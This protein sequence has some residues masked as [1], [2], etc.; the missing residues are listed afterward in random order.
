MRTSEEIYHRVRW[1]PRFDPARFVLGVAVRGAEPQR[2][3]LPAFV[4]GGDIPWHRVV[5]VEA[6][7]ERVWDRATGL[8]RI[9]ATSAGRTL[10]Q[11]TLRPPLFT[12]VTP[13]AWDALAGWQPTA[14]TQPRAAASAGQAT[15]DQLRVLTW[16]TLWDRYDSDRIDTA[17]RRP[18]LVAALARADA[19]VIALQEVEAELLGLLLRADW[20]RS[21]YTVS[22]DPAGGDVA[23]TGLVLLSRLPV[24]EAGRHG[25]GPHK[26]VTAMTV[27]AA[28]DA[29]ITVAVTHLTSDHTRDGAARREAELARLVDLLAGVPG[30]VVLLGDFNDGGSTPGD[31]LG[32]RDAW[33]EVHGPDDR[34]ATFDPPANPLAAIS[35]LTG[36]AS[37]LDR[38]LLRGRTLRAT[39]AT[40]SGT[41]PATPDGL[42]LSDHYGVVVDLAVGATRDRAAE[43]VD[44]RPTPCAS[45]RA[46]AEPAHPTEAGQR[47]QDDLVG[48]IV[49][50]LRAGLP[51]S[52]VHVVGSRRLGC[53][54]AE[55]DLDLVAVVPGAVDIADV[56]H[57]VGTALPQARDVRAVTG[58]RVR[59]LR[60]RCAEFGVDL[61]VVGSAG[62]EPASAVARRMDLG[63]DAAIALSAVS[64]ADALLAAVGPNRAA[65]QRLAR[66]VKQWARA[67]GLDSAPFGGL[68]G[69]AWT[70]L[71]AHTVREAGALPPDQLLRDFFGGWAAWDWRHPVGLWDSAGPAA[72]PAP[73]TGGTAPAV[74]ITTP[75]A[76]VRLCSDQVGTG[77]RDLLTQELYQAWEVVVAA[78]ER[79]QDPRPEL[80]AAPPLHRRHRAW[81]V[82]TVR[83]ERAERLADAV[84]RVRGRMRALL[85]A[86]DHAGATDAHAW[87]RPVASEPGLVR[88]AIGLGRTPPDA[89]TLAG[90]AQD[91]TAGLRGVSVAWLPG[92]EPP[93]PR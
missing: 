34:T 48:D 30:P 18:L 47:Q 4:P 76:P 23:D 53:A 58:A 36:R 87:P 80:L 72:N 90:I 31:V 81:A 54:P 61:V 62:V 69:L 84:G 28:G 5:F 92:G 29:P 88:W 49:R 77:G 50:R 57:R 12:A 37:R 16:N 13:F 85:A 27:Q 40:L 9:D 20:V 65:F 45:T 52:V 59:G 21:A 56:R 55:A 63:R 7:G 71:A 17:R 39:D 25:L 42:F 26:A 51:G 1:D 64:D 33:T 43:A 74:A 32:L 91:W 68:P 2:V 60:L 38:V 82:V 93:T 14:N 10:R 8:D 66:E 79:G 78:A 6:D 11:R 24:L 3:P 73:D 70:V 22:T 19:D 15:A 75:T 41:A 44:A 89:A 86:V 67:R 83:A 46:A 35:S